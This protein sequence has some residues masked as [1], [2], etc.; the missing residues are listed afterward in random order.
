M[1]KRFPGQDYGFT[2][3][4]Y[5]S[6]LKSSF[7]DKVNKMR[8]YGITSDQY[9]KGQYPD[10]DHFLG[11]D[12]RTILTRREHIAILKQAKEYNFI[13]ARSCRPASAKFHNQRITNPC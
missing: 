10:D 3:P 2:L 11:P 1:N 8:E 5:Y 6:H 13:H 7:L 12:D 9:D 4:S